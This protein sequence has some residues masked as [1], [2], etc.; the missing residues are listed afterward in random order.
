MAQH[1]WIPDDT[2]FIIAHALGRIRWQPAHP[3]T[4]DSGGLRFEA[5][6]EFISCL[7]TERS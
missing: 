7:I 2:G 5:G 4:Q 3:A 1:F 6:Q